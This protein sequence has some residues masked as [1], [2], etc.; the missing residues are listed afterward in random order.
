MRA[1][2]RGDGRERARRDAAAGG[3][4]ELNVSVITRRRAFLFRYLCL[5]I[6]AR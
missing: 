1:L 6:I 2:L 5:L 3:G 4:F